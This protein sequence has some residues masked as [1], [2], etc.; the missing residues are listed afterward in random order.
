VQKATSEAWTRYYA[1]TARGDQHGRNDPI[2]LQRARAVF[3][4]R[5][6]I[7]MGLI[8]LVGVLVGYLALLSD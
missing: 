6:G 5:L 3:R 8:T 7:I 1:E 4:E 2:Q